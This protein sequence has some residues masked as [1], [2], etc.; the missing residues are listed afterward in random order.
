MIDAHVHIFPDEFLWRIKAWIERKHNAKAPTGF[1]TK[2]VIEKLRSMEVELFFNLTHSITPEMTPI[3]A[4]WNLK[5]KKVFRC[6]VFSGFHQQ[7]N[8]EL[9]YRILEMGVDGIKLHPSVQRFYPDS[10]EITPVYE[11]LDEL[12]KPLVIHT[13][14]FLDNGFRYSSP[15]RYEILAECYSFPVIFAHMMVGETSKL[16]ELLDSR[17]NIFADTSLALIEGMLKDPETGKSVRFYTEA[18]REVIESYS[19]RIL[20]GS[21]I[22]V[23]WVD[24]DYAINKLKEEFD[25]R[26]VRKVTEDNPE[27]FIRKYL[28]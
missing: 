10:E 20:Y 3:L 25:E 24:P 11:V 17:N 2:S 8:I 7:N 19:D 22:P 15:E 12:E 1:D 4:E 6:Y 21:E 14:F 5:L 28:E 23:I 27:R 16:P 9:L 18:V 26:L 13:G